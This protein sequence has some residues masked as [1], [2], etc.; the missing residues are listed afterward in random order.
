MTG[1]LKR[2]CAMVTDKGREDFRV[3]LASAHSSAESSVCEIPVFSGEQ[4]I[5]DELK[6]VQLSPLALLKP[7]FHA[8]FT[9]SMG[10]GYAVREMRAFPEICFR[11][12]PVMSALWVELTTS[13]ELV[14]Q[15]RPGGAPAGGKNSFWDVLCGKCKLYDD[16]KFAQGGAFDIPLWLPLGDE[17]AGTYVARSDR[18]APAAL[19]DG[20][21]QYLGLFVKSARAYL[22]K[23]YGEQPRV[24]DIVVREWI[25]LESPRVLANFGMHETEDGVFVTPA[26]RGVTPCRVTFWY[27]R[28]RKFINGVPQGYRCNV[29]GGEPI[30]PVM[31]FRPPRTESWVQRDKGAAENM[32]KVDL[33]RVRVDSD[34]E[35][36]GGCYLKIFAPHAR[37]LALECLGYKPKVK[38]VCS[39][40]D[41]SIT[42]DLA[43]EP[44]QIVKGAEA[45]HV[46]HTDMGFPPNKFKEELVDLLKQYP[47]DTV[48]GML[49]DEHVGLR[50]CK[51]T[52]DGAASTCEVCLRDDHVEFPRVHDVEVCGCKDKEALGPATRTGAL[53]V[54]VPLNEVVIL[55]NKPPINPT[56][57]L[58][59]ALGFYRFQMHPDCVG[60]DVLSIASDCVVELLMPP[61]RFMVNGIIV[62]SPHDSFI[63]GRGGITVSY[64]SETEPGVIY[65][66][67]RGYEAY[68]RALHVMC[69]ETLGSGFLN[70]CASRSSVT[71]TV[72]ASGL[73]STEP[74]RE[75][76]VCSVPGTGY[77][78]AEVSATAVY[79]NGLY[80]SVVRAERSVKLGLSGSVSFEMRPGASVGIARRIGVVPVEGPCT[81]R[82]GM[83]IEELVENADHGDCY[84]GYDPY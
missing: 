14:L 2:L 75:L 18:E 60:N 17:V 34:D 10:F 51:L 45:L 11:S 19:S 13:N 1:V 43:T 73:V 6:I 56:I 21:P 77:T 52:G 38:S 7:V 59:N 76:V 39:L 44:I 22:H 62:Q 72:I 65:A 8:Q 28:G 5:V 23:K 71:N 40:F 15:A 80:G 4:P 83:D 70:L 37:D 64:D 68:I 50:R 48:V 79:R 3:K 84:W 20:E 31:P 46:K 53:D 57:F 25:F 12:I 58:G 29:R 26:G 78:M 67:V 49:S 47:G 61:G 81:I 69:G 33:A 66:R 41:A 30:M 32:P 16:C 35:K 82:R 55:S 74:P 27:M 9:G 36:Q 42:E 54:H 24:Y 63:F